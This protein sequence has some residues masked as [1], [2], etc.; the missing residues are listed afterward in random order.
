[1]RE[2]LHEFLRIVQQDPAVD[3]VQGFTGGGTL[4]V[5]ARVGSA[6]TAG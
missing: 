1:M 4:N 3:D 6:E 5:A 2:K